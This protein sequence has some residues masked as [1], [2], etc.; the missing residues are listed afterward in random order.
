MD[1]ADDNQLRHTLAP[2]VGANDLA[3][4]LLVR[5]HG[6]TLVYT[7]NPIACNRGQKRR[8]QEDTVAPS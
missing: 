8:A 6:A 3:F 1:N 2:M 4:R 7:E 5:H